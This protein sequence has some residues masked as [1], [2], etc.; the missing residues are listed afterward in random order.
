MTKTGRKKTH[1][2]LGVLEKQTLSC[3]LV[4]KQ[5]THSH[6]RRMDLR[7]MTVLEGL[8]FGVFENGLGDRRPIVRP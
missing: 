2:R 1:E 3:I 8:D 7:L 4:L 5:R 6:A